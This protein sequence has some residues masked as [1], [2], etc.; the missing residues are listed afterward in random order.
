MKTKHVCLL[1]VLPVMLPVM[2]TAC[3]SV[4]PAAERQAIAE[5]LQ[6]REPADLSP[7]AMPAAD[8]TLDQDLAVRLALANHRG[9]AADLA[10][11]GLARA[12]WAEAARPENPLV[13]IVWKPEESGPDFLDIDLMASVLGVLATP[14]RAAAAEA[15]YEAAQARA[16]LRATDF[17]AEVR[18]AWVD[19]VAAAQR[20]ALQDR[21]AEAAE[22]AALVAEEIHAA[23]N[24]PR[25][26][27][28][29][30]Q[31]F[32]RQARLDAEQARL[33]ARVA[34]LNLLRQIGLPQDAEISLP[35]RLPALPS[36]GSALDLDGVRQ[37]SLPLA[38]ARADAAAA[39]REAG[40]ENWASLLDHAEIG[41]VFER[42]DG[43]WHEGAA[44]EFALPV[45]NWGEARRRA[46]RM[47]LQQA[48]DRH[49]QLE[50]DITSQAVAAQM[51]AQTASALAHEVETAVLPGSADVLEESLRH[52]NAMQIGVFELVAAFQMRARAGQALVDALS[53]AH[54]ADVRLRQLQAGGSPSAAA[55]AGS[56]GIASEHAEG[57]H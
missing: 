7:L 21:I 33:Q 30:E 32:A 22:A 39:A 19:A 50:T 56:P 14:Q 5:A 36:S 55:L 12:E 6:A 49:A 51:T 24:S 57:G 25:L 2:L 20:E 41:L 9:L 11:A 17:V 45:F 13:G 3:V 44:A 42:E 54:R 26:D 43:D 15:R 47:R 28:V 52:Y 23:G 10:E 8:V 16:L 40:L 31:M 4:D 1:L 34:R 37:A 27:L 35:E 46:A 29:R 38:A 53:E 48:L 18:L